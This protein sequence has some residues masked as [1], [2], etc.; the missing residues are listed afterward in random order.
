MVG[1]IYETCEE[2]YPWIVYRYPR[3]DWIAFILG[4]KIVCE[5]LIC[6]CEEVVKISR[7]DIW[8]SPRMPN[9]RHPARDKF[10]SE[11]GHPDKCQNRILWVKPLKNI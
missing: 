1:R 9:Y 3:P 6:G 10:L 7:W 8:A 5:C 11:H 2:G 4:G